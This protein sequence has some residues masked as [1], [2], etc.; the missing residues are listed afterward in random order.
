MVLSVSFN[1]SK[2]S[3]K[4]AY[5]FIQAIQVRQVIV[6]HLFRADLFSDRNELLKPLR[7]LSVLVG[8]IMGDWLQ[9]RI[10]VG[11]CGGTW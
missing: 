7:V 2:A 11:V 4:H 5:V 8:I 9:S 10:V 6:P 3:I 1:S